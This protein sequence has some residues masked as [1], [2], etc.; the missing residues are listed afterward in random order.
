[1][2]PAKALP[3]MF[4]IWMAAGSAGSAPVSLLLLRSNSVSCPAPASEPTPPI[5]MKTWL[6]Y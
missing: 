4:A 1:M 3:D 5:C 2:P 6:I